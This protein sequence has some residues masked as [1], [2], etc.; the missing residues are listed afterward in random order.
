MNGNVIYYR[1]LMDNGDYA[2][3][4]FSLSGSKSILNDALGENLVVTTKA[5]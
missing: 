3:T 1:F 2:E 5:E 4:S